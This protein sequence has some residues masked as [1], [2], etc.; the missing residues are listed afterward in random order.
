[1]KSYTIYTQAGNV[2]LDALKFVINETMQ[3]VIFKGT[4]EDSEEF[5]ALFS[6]KNIYG[7]EEFLYE[8]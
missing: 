3:A 1:M 8:D 5:M 4:E 2:E 6:L 7:F